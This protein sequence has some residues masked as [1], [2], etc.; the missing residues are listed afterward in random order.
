[1]SI[2]QGKNN[3]QEP[4]H[5]HVNAKESALAKSIPFLGLIPTLTLA[6]EMKSE[7]REEMLRPSQKESFKSKE[8]LESFS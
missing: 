7:G 8:C 6:A 4:F 3:P 2:V 5:A 1:M